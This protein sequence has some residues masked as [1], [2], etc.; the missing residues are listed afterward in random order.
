MVSIPFKASSS[1]SL[2]YQESTL[3][4]PKTENATKILISTQY[5]NQGKNETE[6]KL[7]VQWVE[8]KYIISR[9]KKIQG[10][11]KRLGKYFVHILLPNTKSFYASKFSNSV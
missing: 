10:P 11:K 1:L 5:W 4:R 8:N 9:N 3:K 6:L 2:K 7:K